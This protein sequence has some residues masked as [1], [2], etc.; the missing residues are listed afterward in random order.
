MQVHS[1]PVRVVSRPESTTVLLKLV[2][3]HQ[4]KLFVKKVGLLGVG[5]LGCVLVNEPEIAGKDGNLSCCVD[6]AKVEPALRGLLG[7]GEE[8]DNGVA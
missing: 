6:T 8:R 2:T 7:V 5:V 4:D 3:E 1:F